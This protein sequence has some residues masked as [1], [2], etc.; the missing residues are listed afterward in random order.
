M[1]L[2]LIKQNEK[3]ESIKMKKVISLLIA[4]SLIAPQVFA[5]CSKPVTVLNIGDVAPC[6]GYLLSPAKEQELRLMN[7][8]YPLLK[9]E[10]EIKNKKIDLLVKD[11]NDADSIIEKERQQRDLWRVQAE[12]STL[13]LVKQDD[14]RGTRDAILFG[15]GVIAAILAV[16]AAGQLRN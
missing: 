11:A 6:K 4:A 10:I 8:D 16:W 1:Q 9:T 3:L 5:D 7:E 14:S 15:G 2:L 12:D 13:K